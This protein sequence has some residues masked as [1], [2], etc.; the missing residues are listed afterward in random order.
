MDPMLFQPNMLASSVNRQ[1]E[2]KQPSATTTYLIRTA[3]CRISTQAAVALNIRNNGR[4]NATIR[5]ITA[6][7]TASDAYK[8]QGEWH[9]S[10]ILGIFFQCQLVLK[11]KKLRGLT[12]MPKTSSRHIMTPN[13]KSTHSTLQHTYFFLRLSSSGLSSSG[14]PAAARRRAS[15]LLCKHTEI[16]N[17]MF[18]FGF[19]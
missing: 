3:Y 11:K 1:R 9:I 19:S 17:K 18:S 15:S 6:A 13:V 2:L 7:H 10:I 4:A 12:S 16:K 14:W 8:Y 5:R